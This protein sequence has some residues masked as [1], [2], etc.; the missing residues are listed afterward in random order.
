[1]ACLL[2][3]R[4][5]SYWR[6]RFDQFKSYPCLVSANHSWTS[7]ETLSL[8]GMS[9]S[10]YGQV[11]QDPADST[12]LWYW[13]ILRDCRDHLY[14][15]VSFIHKNSIALA[16]LGLI[17]EDLTLVVLLSIWKL[18]STLRL[19]WAKRLSLLDAILG[20]SHLV[21]HLLNAW[22]YYFI[23]KLH[24]TLATVLMD[25]CIRFHIQLWWLIRKE[26]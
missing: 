21:R 1:M 23:R 11:R 2:C 13:F 17:N 9:Y 10:Y 15:V 3:I 8:G 20:Q 4:S 14:L 18:T 5:N 16:F 12:H 25:I 26:K 24:E 6:H 7:S 22:P 19:V